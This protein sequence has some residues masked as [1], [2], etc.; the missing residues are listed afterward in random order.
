MANR[1]SRQNYDIDVSNNKM[2]DMTRDE[3]DSIKL[4]NDLDFKN[5]H[6]NELKKA[7]DVEEIDSKWIQDK[8]AVRQ[9]EENIMQ[10]RRNYDTYKK[11]MEVEETLYSRE[12]NHTILLSVAN[13]LAFIGCVI[14]W[15]SGRK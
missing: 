2:Y 13:A 3:Y 6:E 5:R 1:Y 11:S 9:L 14:V 8:D 12:Y 4:Q 7:S 10:R 15:T